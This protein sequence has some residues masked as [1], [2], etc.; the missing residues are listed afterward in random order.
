MLQWAPRSKF[1]FKYGLPVCWSCLGGLGWDQLCGKFHTSSGDEV[2]KCGEGKVEGVRQNVRDE[3]KRRVW[4]CCQRLVPGLN[5]WRTGLSALFVQLLK[6]GSRVQGLTEPNLIS[7]CQ[8]ESEPAT[9]FPSFFSFFFGNSSPLLSPSSSCGRTDI[10][11]A[12]VLVVVHSN[13]PCWVYLV[14][15]GP[16][17]E[18]LSL[19]LTKT[20]NLWDALSFHRSTVT[21]GLWECFT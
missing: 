4:D 8:F 21:S 5:E 11:A 7:H 10:P 16:L 20:A 3:V 14:G 19:L 2:D 1:Q 17:S 18:W 13:A 15:A 12:D 9:R 6:A